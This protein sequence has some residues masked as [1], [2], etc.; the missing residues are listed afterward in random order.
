MKNELFSAPMFFLGAN[1]PA[2]F[3]SRFGDS[4]RGGEGWHTY[5]IKGGPGT[6]KSTIMKRVAGYF[7]KKGAR[8]HLCPCSSDPNSLDGVIFPDMKVCLLDG[9]APHVVE[10]NYPGAVEELLNLGEFWDISKLNE[11]SEA[12]IKLTDLNRDYHRRGSDYLRAAGSLIED[13]EMVARKYCNREKAE[14]FAISLAK[15]SIHKLQGRGE[16]WLRYLSAVTPRGHVFYKSTFPKLCRNV[17]VIS[18]EHGAASRVVME[19]LRRYA[20]GAGHEIITC[21]CPLSAGE[22][23][24]HIIIPALKIGFAT[25]NRYHTVE[26]EERVIHA[27]RFMDTSALHSEKPH[28]NF[29]RRATADM[30][31][32]AAEILSEAKAVHDRLE[33]LYI[34]AMDFQKLNLFTE[35][36]ILKITA[37]A[38]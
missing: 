18:D 24:E 13:T 23:I 1:S 8:C 34:E 17:T 3:I 14:K 10:P 29:N 15:K 31:L 26:S 5:I 37:H 4:F 2:G 25:S 20:L 21:L 9:T 28:L 33:S 6:G 7:L 11:K 30:L 35:E 38:L 27:R 12:I 19:T 36:L 22:K 16:E 32:S